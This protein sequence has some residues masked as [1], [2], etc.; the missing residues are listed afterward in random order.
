MKECFLALFKEGTGSLYFQGDFIS[1]K[2]QLLEAKSAYEKVQAT[3]ITVEQ[4]LKGI[5]AEK[6]HF[7]EI[8]EKAGVKSF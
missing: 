7:V 1:L 5:V 2:E 8:N 3:N 6:D 4:K